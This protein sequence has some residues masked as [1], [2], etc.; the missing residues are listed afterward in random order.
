[1][2]LTQRQKVFEVSPTPGKERKKKIVLGGTAVAS[3]V[4]DREDWI[5]QAKTNPEFLD[6]LEFLRLSTLA[7]KIP[8]TVEAI[9][10]ANADHNHSLFLLLTQ[11]QT[12]SGTN[13][14]DRFAIPPR[15]I[16]LPLCHAQV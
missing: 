10:A 1:V 2:D 6:L 5:P 7:G 14:L 16:F 15:G 9:V 11:R 12:V 4:L 3:Q 8:R 13:R